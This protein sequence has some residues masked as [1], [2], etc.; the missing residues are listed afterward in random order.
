MVL[1]FPN[2]DRK[3]EKRLLPNSHTAFAADQH[4]GYVPVQSPK[5]VHMNGING[6]N[7]KSGLDTQNSKD[8][9]PVPAARAAR[10]PSPFAEVRCSVP[11]QCSVYLLHCLFNLHTA[12]FILE[13]TLYTSLRT[14]QVAMGILPV[15]LSLRMTCH[16]QHLLI[17]TTARLGSNLRSLSAPLWTAIIMLVVVCRRPLQIPPCSNEEALFAEAWNKVIDD[18]RQRDLLSNLER[19][20]LNYVEVCSGGGKHG[21]WWLLPR[22][23]G[24]LQLHATGAAHQHIGNVVSEVGLPCTNASLP[25]DYGVHGCAHP[26]NQLLPTHKEQPTLGNLMANTVVLHVF[27]ATVGLLQLE[28]SRR[29]LAQV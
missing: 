1:A 22:C 4:G 2:L 29:S 28:L 3:A 24:I 25:A 16:S 21:G 6:V 10:G 5:S 17:F 9:G 19:D 20:R 13:G 23:E 26:L 8:A 18:L 11:W 14:W 7:G 12:H 27:A 15:L